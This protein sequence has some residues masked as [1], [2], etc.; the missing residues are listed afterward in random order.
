ML[1]ASKQIGQWCENRATGN[2]DGENIELTARHVHHECIHHNLFAG[3]G[4]DRH[5]FGFAFGGQGILLRDCES[6]TRSTCLLA[7]LLNERLVA[8]GFFALKKC[9]MTLMAFSDIEIYCKFGSVE[10]WNVKEGRQMLEAGSD[11]DST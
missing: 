11:G 5:G 4:G 2:T 3:I 7:F 6:G 9:G 8:D 10:V 1:H